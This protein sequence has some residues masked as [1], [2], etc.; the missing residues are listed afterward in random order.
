M[1]F[2]VIT[3]YHGGAYLVGVQCAMVLI[4]FENGNENYKGDYRSFKDE[5][6]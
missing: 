6:C 1:T 3:G 4:S 5:I 2:T